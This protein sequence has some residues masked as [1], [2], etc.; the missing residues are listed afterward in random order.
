MVHDIRSRSQGCFEIANALGK[1]KYFLQFGKSTQL[2]DFMSKIHPKVYHSQRLLEDMM[3][4]LRTNPMQ[5]NG[6]GK[7]GVK[8]T[9]EITCVTMAT[10]TKLTML[11]W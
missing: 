6:T 4:D 5:V 3:Q 1:L 10:V 2:V 8:K 7:T 11:L 9:K